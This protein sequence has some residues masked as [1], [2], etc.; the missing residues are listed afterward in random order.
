MWYPQRGLRPVA[1]R[2]AQQPARQSTRKMGGGPVDPSTL[3]W[4][5]SAIRSVLKYDW[6]V[7]APP[8]PATPFVIGQTRR[9]PAGCGVRRQR[10]KR[11]RA[12]D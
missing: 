10:S 2:I 11:P 3:P 9:A 8:S 6:Q 5:D 12:L 4:P 1:A 7:R